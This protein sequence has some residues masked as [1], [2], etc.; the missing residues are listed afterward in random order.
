LLDNL[1]MRFAMANSEDKLQKLITTLLVPLLEKL[2]TAGASV[3]TKVIGLLS[4]INRKVKSNSGITIPTEALAQS[5]FSKPSNEFSQSFKLMYLP[6]AVERSD[7]HQLLSIIPQILDGISGRPVAQITILVNAI[8][9]AIGNISAIGDEQLKALGFSTGP[10]YR[11]LVFL[12]YATDLFMF[13][14]I[15]ATSQPSSTP[16]AA[17]LSFSAQCIVTNDLKAPWTFDSKKLEN[18]K[19][20]LLQI[21]SSDLAFPVNMPEVVHE[22]RLLALACASCDPFFARISSDAKDS[23]KRLC[24]VNFDSNTFVRAAFE[25]ML[26]S[27]KDN[28]RRFPVTVAIRL[29][30]FSYLS[31]SKVAAS[32]F[33]ECMDVISNSLFGSD[34]SSSLRRQ[35]IAFLQ[36]VI[37]SA[38]QDALDNNA[39]NLLQLVRRIIDDSND[40]GPGSVINDDII[41]GSAFVAWGNLA[42]RVS[43]L[44]SDDLETLWTMFSAFDTE[45]NAIHLSIQEALLALLPAYKPGR[46]S[47]QAESKLL[48][49]LDSQMRSSIHQARYCAIRYSISA[50]SF[51]TIEA[52]W[53]CMLGLADSKHEVRLLSHSGLLIPALSKIPNE[54]ADSLPELVDVI[55][56]LHSKV[57]SALNQGSGEQRVDSGHL[58]ALNSLVYGGIIDFV[59]S[60]LL[61]TGLIR[62][63]ASFSDSGDISAY[64]LNFSDLDLGTHQLSTQPLR[65][66]MQLALDSLNCKC[67]PSNRSAS[68]AWMRI[69]EVA[70]TNSRIS[71]STAFVKSF[72]CL[73]ELFSLGSPELAISFFGSRDLLLPFLESRDYIVQRYAA[74][75]LAIVYAVK[76]QA[77][78]QRDSQLDSELWNDQVVLFMN[79]FLETSNQKEQPRLLDRIHGSIL[80]MSHIAL[81]LVVAQ[82]SLQKTWSKL[83]ILR[84][85]ETIDKIYLSL[86]QKIQTLN[87][88]TA[89]PSTAVSLCMAIGACGMVSLANND[90]DKQLDE[91]SDSDKSTLSAIVNIGKQANTVK[92]QDAA[93]DGLSRL[94]LGSPSLDKVFIESMRSLAHQVS[95]KTID[96]H[97]RIGRTVAIAIGGFKCT[98]VELGWT[99]P[100]DPA[101]IFSKQQLEA[102]TRALE[103]ALDLLVNSMAI[104]TNLQDRQAAVVWILS[105]VQMC[106]DMSQIT[107]WLPR[108]HS[109]VCTL[110]T[111]RDDFTREL[112]SNALALIYDRGNSLSRDDMMISLKALFGS[113]NE[114][115][116]DTT[117]LAAEREAAGQQQRVAEVRAIN[118]TFKSIL[119]LALDM[120]NPAL[121]YPLVQLATQTP[122]NNN[123]S[124]S[125]S[126]SSDTSGNGISGRYGSAYGLAVNVERACT[127][128]QPY[129]RPIIPKLFR[130][131]FDPNP[132]T[133]AAM[134]GIWHSLLKFK[135]VK[136][137]NQDI[138]DKNADTNTDTDQRMTEIFWDLIIE[139]CLTS[140]GRFEWQT[141]ES[142]CNAL[143]SAL[144]G[145]SSERIM[146]YLERIW[147]M[148]FRALDDI[149][150]TVRE[151]GLKACQSL[152][153]STVAWCTPRVPANSKHDQQARSIMAIVVPFLV[154]KGIVSDAEDVQKFSLRLTLKLCRASGEYLSPFVPAIVERLLETLSNMEPQA[155]NYLTFHTNEHSMSAEQLESLRLGAVKS[156]PIMQ[157][158]ELALENITAEGMADLVPRLQN[159][160]RHGIGLATR[161]GCARAIAVLCVKDAAIVEPH[162]APLVKAISGSLTESSALQRKAWASA[163]GYMTGMLSPGMMRNLLKHLEK[164]YFNK[165]ESEVRSV[166][167]QVLQQIARNCPEKLHQQGS[168]VAGTAAFIM[169]GCSD[170]NADIAEAFQD[171]WQELAAGIGAD[172]VEKQ[173]VDLL[174]LPLK[175]L[176]D[177][178]W[179]CRVQSAKVIEDITKKLERTASKKTSEQMTIDNNNSSNGLGTN[180]N[181]NDND[182]LKTV[183]LATIPELIRASQGGMWPGK[184]HVLG[185]LVHVC[186]ANAHSF[187]DGDIQESAAISI[188][189]FLAVCD[190]LT[191]QL[192]LGNV[193]YQRSVTE[194]Y[195]NLIEALK[196]RDIYSRVVECLMVIVQQQEV[197]AGPGSTDSS[198]MDTDEPMRQPQ[199]LMLVASATKALLL[200][201]PRDRTLTEEEAKRLSEILRHNAQNGVWNVRVAS[202]NGLSDLVHHC[203]GSEF[204]A[205]DIEA[206]L[207]A[208]RECAIDGKYLAVRAAALGVLEALF[209]A[210][211]TAEAP[212]DYAAWRSKAHAVLKLLA[213]DPVPSIADRAKELSM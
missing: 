45:P 83:G 175:Q 183:A 135:S 118:P 109:C 152:A 136:S 178:R 100:L 146:P 1:A 177:D 22:Q 180:D 128:V 70:L 13:N 148:S 117:G 184:E 93:F 20:K 157:G 211:N 144:S 40:S 138:S 7:K 112:A 202:L 48:D 47:R 153:T 133:Q 14:P 12:R 113:G 66:S 80:A 104:S 163:I 30:I 55:G 21:I 25:K 46:L 197:A 61:A 130:C 143:A 116:E 141:R 44:V 23:I 73:V 115:P 68:L 95:K 67:E 32:T 38:S 34:T 110:L 78:D 101:N 105:L 52:R 51:A 160:I 195:I 182:A 198:K 210:L 122:A 129:I 193:Q 170:A 181:D 156:S 119:S 54:G 166:S 204:A 199:R 154:D 84:L 145:A 120:R 171:T 15:Q 94:V 62:L 99:F 19:Q 167:A 132:Q 76:L 24:P 9:T 140:M 49:F 4:L 108:L 172:A 123:S 88:S 35:G 169:F 28:N 164:T 82:K 137:D 89:F 11:A 71:E 74:Q 126:S 43:L 155:A 10:L 187:I 33:P 64:L 150:A 36:W 72:G 60:L 18:V 77:I 50:F 192:S 90:R 98:L 65:K 208:T 103:M 111:D 81:G 5:T 107:P 200:T 53:L 196:P 16:V 162:S 158:I 56:F 42:K 27:G 6:I 29:R 186:V 63:N 75:A 58:N 189:T 185:C 207:E 31:K 188:E 149:K 173:L 125:S 114:K 91:P 3:K 127:A 206:V 79:G 86:T 168:E 142:G 179:S 191:K 59:R 174:A 190:I 26:G 41:R 121:F 212:S 139:E 213:E 97:F 147:Q 209:A 165:Y 151:S 131:T 203:A 159:I 57:Y 124:G 17:G 92:L 87:K 39:A 102:N 106:P 201:L 161:A 69:I 96:L 37:R 8:F 205:I 176:F 85:G 194:H 134:K 2:D